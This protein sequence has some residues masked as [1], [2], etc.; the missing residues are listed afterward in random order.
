MKEKSLNVVYWCV[1]LCISV[2][3]YSIHTKLNQIITSLSVSHLLQIAGN[4]N[5]ILRFLVLKQF[6]SA[7]LSSEKNNQT[8]IKN[9]K[10]I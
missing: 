1:L 4:K 9:S 8:Y 5:I 2:Y 10:I 6:I 3:I 7:E